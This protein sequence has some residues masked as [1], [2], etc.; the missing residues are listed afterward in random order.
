MRMASGVLRGMRSRRAMFP[1][2]KMRHGYNQYHYQTW[3]CRQGAVIRAVGG[4]AAASASSA[5]CLG[6][7]DS[8]R[9]VVM[10]RSAR[11]QLALMFRAAVRSVA[12][13][14]A[15]HASAAGVSGGDGGSADVEEH[16]AA[17]ASTVN[18]I[19]C[20]RENA[21]FG[22]YQCNDAMKVRVT[23]MHRAL[24]TR[25][26]VQCSH[27]ARILCLTAM[28]MYMPRMYPLASPALPEVG[29]RECDGEEKEE[30]E[31]EG[32]SGLW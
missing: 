31:E 3:N 7:E 22:D 8:G 13:D 2:W 16:A 30:E 6:V 15:R 17:V 11:E 21:R 4:A 19:P 9:D 24:N 25:D 28:R 1:T 5:P 12:E 26:G 20:E 18:V 23:Y 32:R 27:L 14:N 10:R 29:R